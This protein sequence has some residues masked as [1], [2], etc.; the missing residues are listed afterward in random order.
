MKNRRL[1]E[2]HSCFTPYQ[3]W[4]FYAIPILDVLRH[5]NI[6]CFTPYQYWM[7]YAI[8]ILDFYAIGH[9]HDENK[10]GLIQSWTKAGLDL[11]SLG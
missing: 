3:Y 10:F 1:S 2:S 7:F 9:S 5:T 11:F 8:P 4:M 6:G